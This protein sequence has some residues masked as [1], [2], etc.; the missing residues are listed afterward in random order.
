MAEEDTTPF[1]QVP[2]EVNKGAW[3]LLRLGT[4]V[5]V[6]G[7]LSSEDLI[8]ALN[9]P[10]FFQGRVTSSCFKNT[11]RLVHT[12]QLYIESARAIL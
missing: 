9:S 6:A 7:A 11:S 12:L 5:R 10:L 3:C 2:K 8:N 4:A 1:Y